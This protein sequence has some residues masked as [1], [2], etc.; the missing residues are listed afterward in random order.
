MNASSA[1][2]SARDRSECL[3]L[4]LGRPADEPNAAGYQG[5]DLAALLIEVFESAEFTQQVLTPLMLGE[6]LPHE[7]L[8]EVPSFKLLDW[9]QQRLP[10][11]PETRRATGAARSWNHLLELLLTDDGILDLAP[12]FRA[13]GIDTCLLERVAGGPLARATRSVIGVLDAISAFEIR[14]WA[15]DLCDKSTPVTLEFYADNLIIGSV[16]CSEPRPDVQEVVGGDGRSGFHYRIANAH[17]LCFGSGRTV[18]AIDPLTRQTVGA[19]QVVHADASAGWDVLSATRRELGELRSAIERIEARLPDLARIA[20]VPLDSYAEYWERFYRMTPDVAR[21]QREAAAQFAYAPL[22][23]IVMPTWN[24]DARLLGKAIDSVLA[25]T[26][27]H[28]ELIVTDDASLLSEGFRRWRQ[29]HAAEPRIRWLDAADRG[30]I[31][32]NTNRGIAAATGDYVAFLDHDDELTADALFRVAL[33]L[34]HARHGL[35]YSDEDRIEED[36]LGRTLHHTPFFKPALDP[37]LLRSVNYICHFVVLRRDVLDELGGLRGGFDGAQDHDLMLRVVA[38]L[39][40]ADVHHIARIL[41]H[42]RVTP[43]SVSRL[44]AQRETIEAHILA[45]VNSSLRAA[46][47]PAEAHRHEDPDGS[48]RPF[49]TRLRWQLPTPAP[50]ICIIVPTRDRLDLLRPCVESVLACAAGYPGLVR[51]L[52]LDNDSAEAMTHAWFESAQRDPRVQVLH[53]PGSFNWSGINNAAAR[54]SQ[55]DVLIF[56]NN[57]TEARSRDWIVELAAHAMRPDV[58]AVGARLLY[59]DG[60]IQ[61]AGV[62]LG[63]EGVAGHDGVGAAAYSGGYFG[64][65]HLLRSTSAVTG[66]CLATRRAVFEQ[67]GGFDE[68]NLKIAFNDID[69]CM[70][71]RAAGYRIV[72]NPFA[73][74]FHYESKSR[75]REVSAAQQMRHAAE[76]A[77]FRARWG[78]AIWRDPYYNAHFERFALPFDRLRPP[79]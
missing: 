15:V 65:S 41:Y 31:A 14:G 28:W 5:S 38:R 44:P 67:V 23:S 27:G 34:Q 29:V 56:L 4:F 57:D 66:A 11:R 46:A 73:V 37:D 47:L 42:W 72:Y 68:H 50:S 7:R 54:A 12:A 45:A 39:G 52:V 17:R 76:A 25:Q 6:S 3:S 49:A 24:S 20:S 26:Y 18:V 22:I 60:T 75:G 58:G 13:A 1:G 9:I 64:R 30:G 19:P 16:V 53:H 10:L 8:A 71:V 70:K 33:S 79:A 43:G 77:A 62:V 55:E 48:D 61:H 40:E 36:P 74:L 78:D 21:E 63:V 35:V 32:A 69:Y 51:L 2:E 59:A